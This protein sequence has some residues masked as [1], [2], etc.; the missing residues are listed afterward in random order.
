MAS[1]SEATYK[2]L[3]R[4][5]AKCVTYQQLSPTKPAAQWLGQEFF[6]QD[7]NQQE[8]DWGGFITH[9]DPFALR[10][11]DAFNDLVHALAQ[12]TAPLV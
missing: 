7:G 6:V 10:M 1:T 3:G 12:F 2:A 8:L 11:N 9:N 4:D 5:V